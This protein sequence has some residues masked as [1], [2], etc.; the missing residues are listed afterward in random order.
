MNRGSLLRGRDRS[1]AEL[2]T[3]YYY[4][5]IASAGTGA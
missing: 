1:I 3:F 2:V 5:S 4:N